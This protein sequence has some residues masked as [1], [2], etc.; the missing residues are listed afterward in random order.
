MKFLAQ[1]VGTINPPA[2]AV[3]IPAG[4]SETSFVA[5]IIRG[6]IQFILIIGFIVSFIWIIFAGFRFVFSGG[7]EKSISGAWSQIYWGLIGLVV[8]VGA[9]AIIRLVEAFFL[10]DIVSG[11]FLLPRR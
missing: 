6:G 10:V 7:D 2:G 3:S 1:A 8:V 4:Q 5:G 9:F 11:G